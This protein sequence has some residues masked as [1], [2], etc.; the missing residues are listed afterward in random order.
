MVLLIVS[1]KSGW[2]MMR[3][4]QERVG[5]VRHTFGPFLV[6]LIILLMLASNL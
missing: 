5:G 4:G 2:E 1:L 3:C 6:T